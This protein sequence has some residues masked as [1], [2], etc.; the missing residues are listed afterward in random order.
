MDSTFFI[1]GDPDEIVLALFPTEERGLLCF[2]FAGH[3]RVPVGISA[4]EDSGVEILDY[5]MEGFVPYKVL[6]QR[7]NDGIRVHIV[8]SGTNR[9][10]YID[11]FVEK[12][13]ASKGLAF[14]KAAEPGPAS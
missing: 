7:A 6:V 4:L 2:G 11:W 10:Q 9:D 14:Q 3:S 1:V 12:Y 8:K 5:L 13:I